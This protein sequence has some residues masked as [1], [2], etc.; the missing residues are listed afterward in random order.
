M[1]KDKWVP[2]MDKTVRAVKRDVGNMIKAQEDAHRRAGKT[3]DKHWRRFG[4][5][6]ERDMK[7][8]GK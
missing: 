8:V 3:A 7:R 4:K 6:F 1:G 2:E 5:A